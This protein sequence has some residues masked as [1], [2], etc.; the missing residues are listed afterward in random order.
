MRTGSLPDNEL[1]RA[2]R[3]NFHP[4]RSGD[5]YLVFEPNVFINALDGMAVAAA[6]GSPWQYDTFVPVIFAGAGLE[7]RRVSR[8]VAPYDIA[9]TLAVYLGIVPPP[10]CIGE[11][12]PEVLGR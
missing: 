2:V 6:H 1:A 8:P 10:K 11:A 5:I 12:L 4:K 3:R 9:A 7:P